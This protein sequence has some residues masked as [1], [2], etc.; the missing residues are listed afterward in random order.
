MQQRFLGHSGLRVSTLSLGTMT[1]GTTTDE[2]QCRELAKD[3]FDAGGTVLDTA[4]SYGEGRSEAIIGELLGDL[5]PRADVVLI[6]KAGIERRD[7]K[8]MVDCSRR[9]LLAALDAT[10]ARLGTDHLDV[11]LAHTWDPNV[12]LAETLS[13]LDHAVSSGRVRYAGVSNYAGWQLAKAALGV[14]QSLVAHQAEY[15]LLNRKVEAETMPAAEDAGVGLMS[16]GPLGRGVLTGKYRGQIPSDSRGASARAV[17]IEAYLSGRSSRITEALV[18]AAK[19]LDRDPLDVALSWLLD[20]PMLATAVVGPRTPAQL[21]SILSAS[22]LP[23]PEQIV[24]VLD[25]VSA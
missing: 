14:Q 19:G 25:E 2:D 13:A 16:G 21:K 20:R 11:W 9:G 12:P 6:S 7:G 24:N 18:T 23:L 5:V 3:Y 17:E 4:A 22:L 8:R 1:W 10:L 15:S